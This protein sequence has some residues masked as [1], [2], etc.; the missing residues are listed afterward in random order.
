MLFAVPGDLSAPTGGYH[1]ARRLLG[2][3]PELRHLPLPGGFPLPDAAALSRTADALAAIPAGETVLIDGLAL[4]ALPAWV[5][6][7]V[8]AR[9]VALVHHPLCLETGLSDAA[10]AA[11]H[12]SEGAALARAAHVVVTSA[13]TAGQVATMFGVRPDR[14]TVAEPGTDAAERVEVRAAASRLLAVG[15][16]VP[17]K[18]CDVLI[19]ALAGLGPLPWSLVIAGSLDRD[20]ACAASLRARVRALGMDGR[21]ALPG[22]VADG[23]LAALYASA[24]VYVSASWHEGYGMAAAAALARGLPVV[25]TRAGAL[26]ETV[27][28]PAALWCEP[29]DAAGLRAALTVMLTERSVRAACAEASYAAGRALPRWDAA[30]AL[31]RRALA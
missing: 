30:A 5:L 17:R 9:I 29:G 14:T 7:R 16:V 10:R 15:A 22:V 31:V 25:A 6:D 11:L 20:G 1:Y 26:T 18:G 24:D 19:A 2:L 21:V 28:P 3:I 4:G 8:R 13:T 27:P 23:A 12:R